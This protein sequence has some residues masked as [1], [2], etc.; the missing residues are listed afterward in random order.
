MIAS[1]VSELCALCAMYPYQVIIRSSACPRYP[2]LPPVI[3][4]PPSSGSV[5]EG[6]VSSHYVKA[7]A[8]TFAR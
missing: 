2:I 3:R 4:T 8:A 1:D 6:V 7:T 5:E